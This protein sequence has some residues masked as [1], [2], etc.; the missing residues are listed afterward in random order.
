MG[1]ARAGTLA[2]PDRPSV[3]RLAWGSFGSSPQGT[4]QV[5]DLTFTS[6]PPLLLYVHPQQHTLSCLLSR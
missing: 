6:Q 1:I 3:S 4:R 5:H 2:G